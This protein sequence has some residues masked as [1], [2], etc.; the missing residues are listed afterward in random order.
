MTRNNI[1]KS[2]VLMPAYLVQALKANG[3][4]LNDLEQMMITEE[5]PTVR[6]SKLSK[7]DLVDMYT[8]NS[9]LISKLIPN[10]RSYGKSAGHEYMEYK[11]WS[12]LYD[13]VSLD[14]NKLYTE[15]ISNLKDTSSI[16][17]SDGNDERY[18]FDKQE[19]T[20]FVILHSGFSDIVTGRDNSLRETFV[21]ELV[22]EMFKV[23]GERAVIN[24]GIVRSFIS[25]VI[26]K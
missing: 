3:M 6:L 21:R 13:T 26:N 23:Y 19:Q 9:K 25:G 18:S 1:Q 20:L 7:Y 24:N 16:L 12:Y 22:D 5:V 15:L 2:V 10:Y 8:A 4:M 17:M 14:K 11:L